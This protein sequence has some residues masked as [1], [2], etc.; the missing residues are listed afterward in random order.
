MK[1]AQ[2]STKSKKKELEKFNCFSANFLRST[3]WGIKIMSR[4]LERKHTSG[5]TQNICFA[6]QLTG[7][8]MI[9]VSLNSISY[10]YI[11]ENQVIVPDYCFRPSL[12]KIFFVNSF[13]KALSPR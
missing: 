2:F 9:E 4:V 10:S 13:V 5:I 11:L 1:V 6:Y 3:F 12:F 7:F 8:Y